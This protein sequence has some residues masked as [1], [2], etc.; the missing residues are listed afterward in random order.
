MD[1]NFSTT[2]TLS[3]FDHSFSTIEGP[4]NDGVS[5]IARTF[6]Q[7]PKPVVTFCGTAGSP[8][9]IPAPTLFD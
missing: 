6:P 4:I 1:M 3:P 7:R 2:L 8:G 9:S 5:P